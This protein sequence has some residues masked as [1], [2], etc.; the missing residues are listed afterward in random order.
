MRFDAATA[1][2]AGDPVAGEGSEVA[3]KVAR[4]VARSAATTRGFTLTELLV[5]IGIIMILAAGAVPALNAFRR[6]RRLHHAGKIVQ[7]ALNNAR[8]RAITLHVRHVVVPFSYQDRS[9]TL[10]KVRHGLA[11]YSAPTGRK[12]TRGYFPGGYVGKPLFLPKGILFGQQSMQFRVFASANLSNPGEPF[13]A[14]NDHFR[15]RNPAA[16]T[17]LPDGTIQTFNDYPGTHPA[18]GVNIYLPDEG[19]YQV[20][21]SIRADLALIEVIPGGGEVKVEGRTRRALIDLQPMTGRSIAR[22]FDVGD[23]FKTIKQVAP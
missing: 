1:W 15:K 17:F 20:P 13:P 21:I 9:D 14:E 23:G 22:V 11:V 4:K 6:G 10:Q 8:R 18:V 12:N 7:T 16:L 19:Y 3:R 5:V 2:R